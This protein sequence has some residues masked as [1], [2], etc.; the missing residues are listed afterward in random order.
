MPNV[1]RCSRCGKFL[2][3][4]EFKSHDCRPNDIK[5]PKEI[6][7]HHYIPFK[8]GNGEIG[9][10]A[11]GF[12]GIYYRL[13]VPPKESRTLLPLPSDKNLQEQKS[14]GDFTESYLGAPI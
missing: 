4:E 11:L 12:D 14:D 10:M 6:Q 8:L 1:G 3:A 7:I 5:E 13:V 2:I 9:V